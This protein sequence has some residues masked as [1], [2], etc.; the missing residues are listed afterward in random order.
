MPRVTLRSLTLQ[1]IVLAAG[2][3][4]L[5]TEAA[6]HAPSPSPPSP[7]SPSANE[8]ACIPADRC[9]R[10]CDG[11]K[12]CGKSCISEKKTCRVGRGCACNAEEVCA[13]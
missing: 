3:L 13:P 8:P 1:A 6:A 2:A 7:Q 12:A 9:C 11:G 10:I 5:A 4:C